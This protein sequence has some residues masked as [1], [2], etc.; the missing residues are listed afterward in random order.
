M[1]AIH[2]QS[3][4]RQGGYVDNCEKGGI[5]EWFMARL[6]I[7]QNFHL[8]EWRRSRKSESMDNLVNYGD[9]DLQWE[10]VFS[11]S[12]RYRFA[13]ECKWRKA[14]WN[15]WIEWADQIKIAG[16]YPRF[17]FVKTL[18]RTKIM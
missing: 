7:R 15:G 4:D 10:L 5:F 14:L 13:V 11:G 18:S 16:C 3:R 6:F 17:D 9:P 2:T 12:K 8:Q 1:N